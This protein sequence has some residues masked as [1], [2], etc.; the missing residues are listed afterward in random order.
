MRCRLAAA[1]PMRGRH[2]AIMV[3]LVSSGGRRYLSIV[4][5]VREMA[6]VMTI[7]GRYCQL[8]LKHSHTLN[9]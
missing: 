4:S 5:P 6:P 1:Q 2:P 7:L 8:T 3:E 9:T